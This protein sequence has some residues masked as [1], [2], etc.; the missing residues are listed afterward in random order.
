MMDSAVHLQRFRLALHH[1]N[2]G[3]LA[4]AAADCAVLRGNAPDD[5]AVLQLQATLSLRAGASS[6][7]WQAIGQALRVRPDHVPSLMLGAEIARAMGEPARAIPLLQRAAEAAPTAPE[8]R[9]LLLRTLVELGEAPPPAV[10]DALAARFAGQ[11]AAWC[12][13]GGAFDR[14]GRPALAERAFGHAVAADPDC[15]SAHL[16]RGLALGRQHDA[17]GARVAL[18]RALA[19]DPTAAAG[20]F[21]LG[22]AC[23]DLDDEPA[24]A[25][26]YAAALEHR[27]DFAEAAVNLGIALQRQG[28]MEAALAA[29]CDAVRIRPDTFGRIAQAITA[30]ST[31]CL[32]LS[33]GALRQRLGVAAIDST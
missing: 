18:E 2:E 30:S 17:A 22:L 8:A 24:A 21:A 33:P 9:F 23:Q 10:L 20:W 31:G 4:A 5:P 6:D 26:A 25:A 19:L 14:A 12:E 3:D 15:P 11:A 29:Y 27:P 28:R 16:G 32:W 13:L 7:A 1:L